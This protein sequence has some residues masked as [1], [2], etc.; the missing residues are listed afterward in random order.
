MLT[1]RYPFSGDS[2]KLNEKLFGKMSEEVVQL[3]TGML[4]INERFSADE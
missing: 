4:S 3:M 1:G 2:Y